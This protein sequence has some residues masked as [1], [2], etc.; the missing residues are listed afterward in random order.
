MEDLRQVII[1]TYRTREQLIQQG[2]WNGQ[3]YKTSLSISTKDRAWIWKTLLLHSEEED[4]SSST[5]IYITPDSVLSNSLETLIPVP[6]ISADSSHKSVDNKNS[7]NYKYK[8]ANPIKKFSNGIRKLTPKET[9]LHPLGNS[10][11]TAKNDSDDTM[12]LQDTLEIVDLDLSRLMIDDIFQQPRIHAIMRQIMFNYLVLTNNQTDLPIEDQTFFYRQGYHEILGIIFLQ[13]YDPNEEIISQD[14]IK[15]ILLIFI[16]LMNPLQKHFYIEKNLLHWET[17][18]F[19]KILKL[20]SPT[21]YKIFYPTDESNNMI[22]LIRWSRLLFLREL[23]QE[24]ILIIWDHLLT[25]SYSLSN[26]VACTII[27]ILLILQ[28]HIIKIVEDGDYDDLIE[29][30]LR[31]NKDQG[32]NIDVLLVS[33][34]MKNL[35]DTWCCGQFNDLKKIGDSFIQLKNVDPNRQRLENKLR[36]RVINSLNKNK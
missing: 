32:I 5:T 11:D 15:F 1:G 14:K 8:N 33:K 22:W 25:F 21:L 23:P 28:D 26:M 9:H 6:I 2:I 3:L 19:A 35:C 27:S 13:F 36:Q 31:F 18:C 17:N 7:L 4:D 16:K 24:H 10:T 20:T 29:F 30:M 34:T 12:S